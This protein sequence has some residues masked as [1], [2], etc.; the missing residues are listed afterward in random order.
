[1]SK[2]TFKAGRNICEF[3]VLYFYLQKRNRHFYLPKGEDLRNIQGFFVIVTI[4]MLSCADRSRD[5]SPAPPLLSRRRGWLFGRSAAA[6]LSLL[7]VLQ[8]FTLAAFSLRFSPTPQTCHS[9]PPPIPH[10]HTRTHTRAQTHT[11][12]HTPRPF[13]SGEAAPQSL[14]SRSSLTTHMLKLALIIQITLTS[15]MNIMM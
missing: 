9:Q 6:V 1:M 3:S 4:Q 7:R 11:H 13:L 12:T 14:F 2:T 10:T 8:W 15:S 5:V